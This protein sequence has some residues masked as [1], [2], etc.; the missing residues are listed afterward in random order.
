MVLDNRSLSIYRVRLL[1][2]KNAVALE[3]ELCAKIVN[4]FDVFDNLHVMK[5]GDSSV[6]VTAVNIYLCSRFD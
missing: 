1:K 5:Q 2:P 6:T 3:K 4:H